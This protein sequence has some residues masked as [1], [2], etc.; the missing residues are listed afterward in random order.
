MSCPGREHNT[1]K[2]D[3]RDKHIT[4]RD[5]NQTSCVYNG[6]RTYNSTLHA[7][8]PN[9]GSLFKMFRQCNSPNNPFPPTPN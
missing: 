1:Q 3:E 6:R 5:L 7:L 8:I 4:Y 9:N 2:V